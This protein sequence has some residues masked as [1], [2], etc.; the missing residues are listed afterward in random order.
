M[1]CALYMLYSC[2]NKDNILVYIFKFLS[3]LCDLCG[4]ILLFCENLLY[5]RGSVFYKKEWCDVP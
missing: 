5:L 4:F 1:I 2:L 3:V